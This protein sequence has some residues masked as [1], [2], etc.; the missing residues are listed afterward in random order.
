MVYELLYEV[1]KWA[2]LSNCL[3]HFHYCYCHYW[4]YIYQGGE[5]ISC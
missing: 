3:V 2:A 5:V 1:E 4:V